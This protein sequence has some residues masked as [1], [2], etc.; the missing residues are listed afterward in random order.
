M[1]ILFIRVFEHSYG[2]VVRYGG[3]NHV[4]WPFAYHDKMLASSNTPLYLTYTL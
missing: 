4:T 3:L 1:A 2:V